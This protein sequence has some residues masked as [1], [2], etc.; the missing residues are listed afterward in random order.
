MSKKSTKVL[1]CLI[2]A[3]MLASL[4]SCGNGQQSSAPSSDTPSSSQETASSDGSSQEDGGEKLYYNKEGDRICDEVI[5][6]RLESTVN[7]T[8]DFNATVMHDVIRD[9]FGIELECTTYASA[10]DWKTQLTLEMANDTLPDICATT[11]LTPADMEKYGVS[12]GYFLPISD[13]KD[14]APNLYKYL[15]AYPAYKGYVTSSDGKIYGLPQLSTDATNRAN[16]AYINRL[17]LERLNLSQPTTTDELYN[18]LKAFKEQDAD[19]D[20]DPSNEIP[21]V[22]LPT[23]FDDKMIMAAFGLPTN[24]VNYAL[25]EDGGQVVFGNTT[26]NYKAYLT[27]MHKLYEEGLI[28]SDCFILSGSDG[29][30]L[31]KNGNVGMSGMWAPFV[32]ADREASYDAEFNW[33]G[34]LTSEYSDQA[35]IPLSNPVDAN[36]RLL[37]SAKTQYPEA[38]VRL[39]DYFCTDEGIVAAGEGWEGMTFHYETNELT[40]DEDIVRNWENTQYSTSDEYRVQHAVMNSVFTVINTDPTPYYIPDEI[41]FSDEILQSDGWKYLIERGLRTEGAILRDTFPRLNFTTEEADARSSLKTEVTNYVKTVKSK[42]IIGDMDI[43]KDWEEY[44][45]ELDKIGLQDLMKLEQDAYARFTA[46]N[47]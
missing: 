37:F 39:L 16:R 40:G 20:G 41:L 34:A 10:D 22:F 43:E 24:E 7:S 36:L 32:S 44:L 21:W 4:V 5:T 1:T 17:W 14:L 2:A 18:V 47:Q 30:A 12:Q 33:I 11:S 28:N 27:Y 9:R 29:Q 6:V 15:D 8:P 42:F 45:A 35:L 31:M 3:S 13:Y 38:L 26:E 25:I 23:F 46:T 19:G